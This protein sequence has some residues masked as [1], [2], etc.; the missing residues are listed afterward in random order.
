MIPT[1]GLMIG[2][3]IIIRMVSFITRSGDRKESTLVI[4]LSILNIF[5]TLSMMVSLLVGGK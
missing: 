4:V 3:Y 2:L 5:V 1:I